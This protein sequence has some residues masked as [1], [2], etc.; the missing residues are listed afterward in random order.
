MMTA[1][2]KIYSFLDPFE[3]LTRYCFT[4]PVTEH[5]YRLMVLVVNIANDN[6]DTII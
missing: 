1:L 5:K 2:N 3:S 4:N 6:C